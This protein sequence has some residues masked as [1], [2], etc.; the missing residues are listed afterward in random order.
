MATVCTIALVA[1]V[2]RVFN[3]LARRFPCPSKHHECK[4]HE[5]HERCGII[6]STTNKQAFT[7]NDDAEQALGTVVPSDVLQRR[8]IFIYHLEWLQEWEINLFRG[9]FTP[10]RVPSVAVPLSR[11][12]QR[13]PD[14]DGGGA[15]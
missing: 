15:L 6:V 9:L 14:G 12:V 7:S 1:P 13:K 3:V 2:L 5:W 11:K 8:G 10:R 4:H